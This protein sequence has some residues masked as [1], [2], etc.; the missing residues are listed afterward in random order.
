MLNLNKTNDPT[1]IEF[2]STSPIQ[3]YCTVIAVLNLNGV[4]LLKPERD[5]Q[6][7]A[8]IATAK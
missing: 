6:H 2:I 3:L 8:L 1:E 4:A 5:Y 7:L